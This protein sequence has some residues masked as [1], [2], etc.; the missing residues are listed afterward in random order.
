MYH[1]KYTLCQERLKKI[2]RRTI[3]YAYFG[4]SLARRVVNSSVTIGRRVGDNRARSNKQISG[5]RIAMAAKK[6]IDAKDFYAADLDEYIVNLHRVKPNAEQ[7]M[8]IKPT[9]T[10]EQA[11]AAVEAIIKGDKKDDRRCHKKLVKLVAKK[12]GKPIV[13]KVYQNVLATFFMTSAADYDYT[14][15]LNGDSHTLSPRRIAINDGYAEFT[16]TTQ[17]Y[18]GDLAYDHR[19]SYDWETV[20][21]DMLTNDIEPGYVIANVTQSDVDKDS[22]GSM[23]QYNEKLNDWL[24]DYQQKAEGKAR[25]V[26][27][28]R[29]YDKEYDY[30]EAVLLAPYILVSYAL[31]NCIVTFSVNAI[32][33]WV[34]G[35]MIN[36][37][38]AKF[39]YDPNAAVGPHFSIPLFIV[40]SLAMV[41]LGGIFYTLWYLSA[42]SASK[43]YSLKGYTLDELKKLL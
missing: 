36:N 29:I 5:E 32:N 3:I 12:G 31:G 18:A 22:K 42:K 24:K 6:T 40:A 19:S 39:D 26:T 7:P 43:K 8:I 34:E 16:A 41:V 25:V 38:S 10:A 11:L 23:K 1:K 21:K 35:A 33:G 27:N 4:G 20:G 28:I 14:Y 9:T 15:S 37:P 2:F 30:D 13:K 17:C